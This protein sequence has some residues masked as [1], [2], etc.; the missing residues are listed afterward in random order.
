MLFLSS[1]QFSFQ[2]DVDKIQIEHKTC[3]SNWGRKCSTQYFIEIVDE[4]EYLV[5]RGSNLSWSVHVVYL[6]KSISKGIGF[7]E[8]I[9]LLLHCQLLSLTL[10]CSTVWSGISTD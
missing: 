3:Y 10:I 4:F 1:L 9:K 8:D 6:C 2:N 7:I 5:K